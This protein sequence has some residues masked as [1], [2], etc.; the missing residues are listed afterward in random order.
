M[1]TV[2]GSWPVRCDREVRRQRELLEAHDPSS[3]LSGETDSGRERRL[4][5]VGIRVPALLDGADAE[6]GAIRRPAACR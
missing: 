6:R 1:G 5:R 2:D 4:V 3:M